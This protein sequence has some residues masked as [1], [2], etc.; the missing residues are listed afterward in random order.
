MFSNSRSDLR[1]VAAVA[2]CVI[3][4]VVS[5][6]AHSQD[7]VKVGL[8][9]PMTGRQAST[10]REIDAAIRLYVQQHGDTVAG[11]KIEIILKDDGAVPENTKRLAQELIVDEKANVLAGFGITPSAYVAAPLLTEARIPGIVM[12][13]GSSDVTT[14]SPYFLRTGF[15][16]AQSST[17][18]ADWAVQNGIKTVATIVSD[19]SPGIDAQN[20]FKERFIT[21]G[22]RV[23]EEI[24]VPLANPDFAPFL[25]RIREVT[26][27]AVFIFVPSGQVMFMNQFVEMGLD[28]AGIK[29][30]GPGDITDDDQLPS[31]RDQVIGTV[32]A[33]MYSAAHNSHMNLEYVSEFEKANNFRPNFMSVAGYDGMHLIY[34]ALRKTG[35]NSDGDALVAA[36]K[37][38]NWES[39]RGPISIDPRTRDIVQNIYIRRVERTNG[40]LYN[41]EFATFDAV[42]DPQKEQK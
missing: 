19:Y 13:A 22:N 20:S 24:R 27:D 41:V 25:Q 35:G 15:T 30:L 6:S 4:V 17:I 32:T 26:P 29:I 34:E 5:G 12:A 3:A 23:V 18:I 28:K 33:H 10:G 7:S 36:M 9:V 37:G 31:M 40:S 21:S 39:P 1:R 16:M 14:K 2:I 8:I 42:K 11:R 38:M